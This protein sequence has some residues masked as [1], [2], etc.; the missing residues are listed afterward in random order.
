[1]RRAATI[2]L[3]LK[4]ETNQDDVW[5]ELAAEN[6]NPPVFETMCYLCGKARHTTKGCPEVRCI[7]CQ[8]KGHI[9]KDCPNKRI[10]A[11]KKLFQ[12]CKICNASDHKKADCPVKKKN[13]PPK[14]KKEKEVKLEIK[15]EHKA[16]FKKELKVDKIKIPNNALVP[17]SSDAK[18]L[19][20]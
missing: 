14:V 2:L 12:L 20:K 17:T 13:L 1:M 4:H 18:H 6:S 15:K 9:V 5:H 19:K 8:Q 10:K 11:K 16:N 3:K 7:R